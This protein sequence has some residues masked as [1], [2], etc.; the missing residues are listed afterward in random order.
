VIQK[1]Q[2]DESALSRSGEFIFL[3]ML[4]ARQC[5]SVFVLP[6]GGAGQIAQAK[7][8][9][10]INPVLMRSRAGEV[11]SF[12]GLAYSKNAVKWTRLG[13]SGAV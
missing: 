4:G 7:R 2:S 11:L 13:T 12:T 9:D 8:S 3:H 6:T 5:A 10:G 1:P